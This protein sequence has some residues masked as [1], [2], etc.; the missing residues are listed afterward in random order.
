MPGHHPGMGG[1]SHSASSGPA[2]GASSGGNYGGNTHGGGGGG[3]GPPTRHNPHTQSGTSVASQT[4]AQLGLVSS[5]DEYDTPDKQHWQDTQKQISKHTRGD[6]YDV[7]MTS[8]EYKKFNKE[9]NDYYGTEGV[10]YEPYGKAGQGTTNLTFQEHW[11]NL[12]HQVPA[13]KFSPTLRFLAAAGKNVG[14]YL[15]TD[16]GTSKYAGKDT[17]GLLGNLGGG[18]GADTPTQ[19]QRDSEIMRNIAPEAPYIVSGLTKPSDS[20]AAKWY[21]SLGQTNTSGFT[22][23]FANELAAAKQKQAVILGNPSAV[24]MLAVS[25]SPFYD[26][27]KARNLDKGIL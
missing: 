12:G 21:Q 8:E 23:S 15:T 22:F 25:N 9:L 7:K 16:Y 18:E 13:L 19:T 14:E 11:D 26:F 10:K 5:D 6:H 20:P 2:G 1:S 17:G 27:L 24:G 3:D 4:K